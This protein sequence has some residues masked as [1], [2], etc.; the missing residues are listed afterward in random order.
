L[1]WEIFVKQIHA[2]VP[3]IDIFAGPGGLGEGFSA[4]PIGGTESIFKIRL[5]LEK[6]G[7]RSSHAS[8]AGLLP[9]IQKGRSAGSLLSPSKA[10]NHAVCTVRVISLQAAAAATEALQ[11]TLEPTTGNSPATRSPAPLMV[12]K[13]GS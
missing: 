3:V 1:N 11:V 10:G 9:S 6:E 12:S 13:S 8:I 7:K 4:Y 5:S 2:R